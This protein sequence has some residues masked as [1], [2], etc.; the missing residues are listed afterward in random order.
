ME[1][2]KGKWEAETN[3]YPAT[4]W[5]KVKGRETHLATIE[6][7]PNNEDTANA[8]LIAAAPAMYEALKN[9][10]KYTCGR[11][12]GISKRLRLVAEQALALAR[13]E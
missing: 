10:F 12:D 8:Y 6:P 2:T 7:Q 3:L 13:R 1:Y 11:Q 4:V 5:A 9:V